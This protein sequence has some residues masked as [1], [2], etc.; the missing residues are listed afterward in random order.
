MNVLVIMTDD[1]R[2]DT[3]DK[4]P[5][6]ADLASQGVV[7][8]RAYAPTPLCS[9]S[10]A[11]MFSGGYLE[12]NTG[13]LENPGPNGGVALFRDKVNL[14]TLMQSAGYRTSFVG[15]WV[16][17]YESLK[18]YIP[19]GWDRF[20]G[21][22]SVATT[23]DWYA[24]KYVIGSSGQSSALGTTVTANDYTT[25]YERDQVLGLLDAQ[26]ASSQPFFIFW[27][28]TAPHA[29]ATPAAED[30]GLFADY[31]YRDRGYGET[32]LSDKPRWVRTASKNSDGSDDFVRRQLRSLQSVDRS[33]AAVVDKLRTIGK[34]DNTLVVFT[35]DNGYMWGE[36]GLWGKPRSYEEAV[37]LPFIVLMPGVGPRQDDHLVSPMLDL[38]PTLFELAGIS[39]PADGAS[40]VPLLR[41]PDVPWRAD[42]FLENASTAAYGGSV[43]AGTRNERWKYVRYFTGEEELYDLENDPFELQSR[44]ADPAV[45]TIKSELAASTTQRLGLAINPVSKLPVGKVGATYAFQFKRWGGVGPFSWKIDSG[46]LPS[47]LSLNAAN[48]SLSGVPKAAGSYQ[49]DVRI[50]DSVLATQA[51]V[52]RTYVT[53]RMKIVVNP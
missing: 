39:H 16:N 3:I 23:A 45:A 22:H 14:G 50:T 48:G 47:G 43:W 10:R 20:V 4:M 8:T 36:H 41:N 44:H 32:D 49:F 6:T 13:V 28:P 1:Q 25:Y 9:P 33:I 34:L 7:F 15:K 17:G 21:R 29:K 27:S 26:Q 51:N 11:S 42:F 18:N 37:R 30:T 40:L 2:F 12:Q 31:A 35:S 38:G 52:P 5:S 53:R 46:A 19:P 24:F